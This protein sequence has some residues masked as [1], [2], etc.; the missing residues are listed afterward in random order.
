MAVPPDR[1]L[2]ARAEGTDSRG[3]WKV[4]SLM[5]DVPEGRKAARHVM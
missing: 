5:S 2:V 4:R 3:S 1:M